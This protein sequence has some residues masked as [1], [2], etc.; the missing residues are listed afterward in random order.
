MST[1]TCW[2]S[3]TAA[4]ASKAGNAAKNPFRIGIVLIQRV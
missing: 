1:G 3:V 4:Q 2:A